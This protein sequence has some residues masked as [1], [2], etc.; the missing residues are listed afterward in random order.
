MM[1]WTLIGHSFYFAQ[2]FLAN[3]DELRSDLV[4]NFWN[5]LITNFTLSVDV[6]FA[7]SGILISYSWFKKWNSNLSAPDFSSYPYWLRY[8]RHRLVRLW[9]AYLYTLLML[10][11][12]LSVT[13]YHPMFP[14]TDPA[15]QCPKH[16]WKNALMINSLVGTLCMPCNACLF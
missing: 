16:W 1:V 5:Q 11:T 6:F 9:P 8:V 10:T 15:I 2:M 3:A 7:L 12:R 13:H 14:A 4:D